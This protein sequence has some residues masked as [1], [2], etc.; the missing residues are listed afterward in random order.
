MNVLIWQEG[1]KGTNGNNVERKGHKWEGKF[2]KK[3]I[4]STSDEHTEI[5]M[6]N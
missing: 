5:Q 2:T 4:E 6:L 1:D 3:V